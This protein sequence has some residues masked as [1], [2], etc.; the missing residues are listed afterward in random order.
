M[1]ILWLL[2]EAAYLGKLPWT[3]YGVWNFKHLAVNIALL[4][5]VIHSSSTVHCTKKIT[6]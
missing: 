6:K 1:K 5:I 4:T 2:R 3:V